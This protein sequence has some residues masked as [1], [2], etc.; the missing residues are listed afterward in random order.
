M[1]CSAGHL[2]T[3]GRFAE[4]EAANIPESWVISGDA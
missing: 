1:T 2:S 4:T 3:T